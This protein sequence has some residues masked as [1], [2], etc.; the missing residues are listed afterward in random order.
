MRDA[1]TLFEQFSV[2][3]VLKRKYIEENLELIGDDFLQEFTVSLITKD[4]ENTLKN[5]TFLREK[6]LDVRLFIEQLLFFLRDRM[7]ESLKKSDFG[8]YAEL[9][10]IFE[11]IYSR[12]KYSPD[13]F[14]LLETSVFRCIVSSSQAQIISNIPEKQ[15]IKSV[16]VPIKKQEKIEENPPVPEK[17]KTS[18][19]SSETKEEISSEKP[20]TSFDFALFIEHIRT[21]PKRS[22]V[23]LGLRVATYSEKGKVI[24]IH[25]D[26]DFNYSKLN[27]VDVRTFLQETLDTLFGDGYQIDIQK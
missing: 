19:A 3:G 6:S 12:L 24:I 25:P 15:E 23:G 5:L 7:K 16:A 20:A 10:E 1:I 14:L 9:F 22:F 8:S 4:T 13:P 2:G 18:V 26:N 17:P 21:V 11:G 27:S